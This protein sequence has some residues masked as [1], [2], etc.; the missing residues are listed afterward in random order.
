MP[1][2][3]LDTGV[4][5]PPPP[6]LVAR[7]GGGYDEMLD[8]AAYNRRVID[9]LLPEGWDYRGK[10]VLD[11]GCGI[12]RTVATYHDRRHDTEVF[13][14]DI[15][16]PSIR[17]AAEALS[18]PFEFFVCDE[19]PP[20]AQPEARFHLVYACSVFTHITDAWARWL[21]ELARV[22]RPGGILVAS[23][24]N[25]SMIGPVFGREWD[26]RIGMAT[27]H[28]GR[29][30]DDG[31]PCVLLAE[32]WIRE[33]W[34]RGFDIL[35]FQEAA[36][37]SG[38]PVGHGWVVARRR[39]GVFTAEELERID[40]GDRREWL[41]REYNLEMLADEARDLGRRA[42]RGEAARDVL[43]RELIELRATLSTMADSRSWRLTR[44]LR[45]AAA[46]ARGANLRHR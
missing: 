45:R 15:H 18:P 24:L 32:W 35:H 36:N 28:L 38:P 22:L 33:H 16:E 40:P 41:A 10:A 11:F 3:F 26:E 9:S 27:A 42:A 44:P 6:E 20:L 12:G 5:P 4:M 29:D 17:W 14:C 13:G 7:V 30:W 8:I 31:G 21:V 37:S 39:A 34:G 1:G 46:A 25:R 19:E 23:V 2:S 43:E